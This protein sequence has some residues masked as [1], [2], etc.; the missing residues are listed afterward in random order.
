[1]LLFASCIEVWVVS[2]LLELHVLSVIDAR[3][4]V[5]HSR[6][7]CIPKESPVARPNEA[8]LEL[9]QTLRWKCP[10]DLPNV[11]TESWKSKSH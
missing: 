5:E 8:V 6:C 9:N 1:M 2:R 7:E 10:D 3:N 4:V 11:R